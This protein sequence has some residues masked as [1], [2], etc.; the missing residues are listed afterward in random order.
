MHRAGYL[1]LSLL[2][3][4]TTTTVSLADKTP[5]LAV[6]TKGPEIDLR[7]QAN[8]RQL[9]S[10]LVKKSRYTALVFYRSADW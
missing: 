4:A 7:D 8:N 3:V 9:L 10:K 5:G 1:L 6:G 2:I